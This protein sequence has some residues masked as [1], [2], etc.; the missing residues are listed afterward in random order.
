MGKKLKKI[1]SFLLIFALTLGSLMGSLKIN[2]KAAEGVNVIIC[3]DKCNVIKGS[4]AKLNALDALKDVLGETNVITQ[5]TQYGELLTE[6]KYK[7]NGED[8]A[9]KNGKYGGFDSWL[10]YVVKNDQVVNP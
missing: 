8:L 5:S 6:I 3:D 1:L 2:A 10:Y 4:S 9:L 7:V